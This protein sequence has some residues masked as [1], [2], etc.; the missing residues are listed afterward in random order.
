MIAEKPS[1]ARD[2]YLALSNKNTVDKKDQ[3]HR[4]S[5]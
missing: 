1:I 2:I 5:G 4:F 3:Y